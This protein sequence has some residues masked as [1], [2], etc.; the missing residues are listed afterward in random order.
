MDAQPAVTDRCAPA[1]LFMPL[2]TH[3]RWMAT[4]LGHYLGDVAHWAA[5]LRALY[6]PPPGARP[7]PLLLFPSR[8]MAPLSTFPTSA[9]LQELLHTAAPFVASGEVAPGSCWRNVIVDCPAAGAFGHGG[10]LQ[11]A[12]SRALRI[13]YTPRAPAGATPQRASLLLALRRGGGS[14]AVANPAELLHV[15]RVAGLCATPLRAVVASLRSAVAAAAGA[16]VLAGAHGAD[17][18]LM[19]FMRN[20]SVVVELVPEP[21]APLDAFYVAQAEGGLTL[22]RWL[23]P[24]AEHVRWWWNE[25]PPRANH[26]RASA[27]RGSQSRRVPCVMGHSSTWPLAQ[28]RG[29]PSVMLPPIE[30]WKEVVAEAR[31]RLPW[32]THGDACPAAPGSKC[33]AGEEKAAQAVW[34]AAP[35]EIP[36]QASTKVWKK[37]CSRL[38][39]SVQ[40]VALG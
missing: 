25:T 1:V 15:A 21:I 2:S 11:R 14:R 18:S 17:L 31:R 9:G 34:D 16:D 8:D 32:P 12:L 40:R 19:S 29:T 36:A 3:P 24:T 6:P 20:G 28:L 37:K 33:C 22:L 7:L 13:A 26:F 35:P 10:A 5:G 23:L 38:A 4:N 27:G 30:G 39:M